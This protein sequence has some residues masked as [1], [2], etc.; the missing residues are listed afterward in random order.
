MIKALTKFTVFSFSIFSFSSSLAQEDKVEKQSQKQ[1]LKDM[2][3][4]MDEN[5]DGKLTLG[6]AKGT[7]LLNFTTLD[8]NK[9]GVLT[10]EDLEKF[11]LPNQPKPE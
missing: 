7:L 6:E 4:K 5:K 1:V 8:A 3:E 11:D 10:K 9:D 2:F